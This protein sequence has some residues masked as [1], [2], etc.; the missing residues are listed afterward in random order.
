MAGV[1]GVSV[2]VVAVFYILVLSKSDRGVLSGSGVL[3]ILLILSPVLSFY[4]NKVVVRFLAHLFKLAEPERLRQ[5]IP[6]REGPSEIR[7]RPHGPAEPERPAPKTHRPETR[8]R[9]IS[10]LKEEV[11]EYDPGFSTAD[12]RHLTFSCD[13]DD[14]V[15]SFVDRQQ[16]LVKVTFEDLVGLMWQEASSRE[17]EPQ[18]GLT[19]EILNSK[20]LNL[21]LSEDIVSQDEGY[22]HFKFCFGERGVF[23]ILSISVKE[24]EKDP[25]SRG[26]PHGDTGQTKPS[27][28]EGTDSSNALQDIE[29]GEASAREEARE[30]HL[31]FSTADALHRDFY[32]ADR[33]FVLNI[34]DWGD[35]PFRIAFL[36]VL[37]VKYQEAD[38]TGPEPRDDYTYE[39]L[40]SKWLN[41]HYSQNI[42]RPDEGHRHL[43]LCFNRG[44][45]YEILCKECEVEPGKRI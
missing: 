2:S 9:E 23:E 22:R 7:P 31:G 27:D 20:W 37:G 14:P 8:P 41:T 38:S 40:N 34:V 12:A 28:S 29:D 13:W 36:D 4:S 25:P 26:R 16:N 32:F 17:P 19:W 5:I 1:A 35:N 18:D 3:A 24:V 6:P 11:R 10:G 30:V 42:I 45:V 33:E 43:K 15:M 39:I 21:H 44:G